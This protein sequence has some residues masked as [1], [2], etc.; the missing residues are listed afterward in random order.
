MAAQSGSVAGLVKLLKAP[1]WRPLMRK[2]PGIKEL[3]RKGTGTGMNLI[4]NIGRFLK[5]TA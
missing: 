1:I 4:T 5:K 3:F 2:K